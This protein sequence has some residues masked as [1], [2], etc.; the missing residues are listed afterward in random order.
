MA[1]QKS[2][3]DWLKTSQQYWKGWQDLTRQA[4]QGVQAEQTAA[5]WHEGLE[6]WSR[7][8]RGGPG[9]SDMNNVLDQLL[10]HGRGYLNFLQQIASNPGSFGADDLRSAAQR[11]VEELR[12]ASP[13]ASAMP[14]AGS[15]LG[16]Q[17]T[18]AL[19]WWQESVEP[20]REQA[21]GWSRMPAFGMAREYTEQAQAL[22]AA[23]ERLKDANQR[24]GALIAKALEGGLERFQDKLAARFEPG[25][26][27]VDDMRA[28]YDLFIDGLEEAY[29]ETA[30][31]AEFRVVYGDLVNA[32]SD[33]RLKIQRVVEQFS[34]TL[35][36]P[37]RSEINT[38][39]ARVHELRRAAKRGDDHPA[40][41]SLKGEIDQLRREL[42][43]LKASQHGA[44]HDDDDL[45]VAPRRAASGRKPAVSTRPVAP[46]KPAKST[47]P[48]T[49]RAV[50]AAAK[51][52]SK[53]KPARTAKPAARSTTRTAKGK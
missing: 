1:A 53:A 32:Q 15:P 21:Q 25:A 17:F 36:I 3:E 41:S 51:P 45:P 5:P 8:F 46:S 48:A 43:A 31:S 19:K 50:K 44:G 9:Q 22:S 23:Q 42:A 12:I 47:S 20:M 24:Y 18:N 10:D 35:G 37:T 27:R 52:A 34:G 6:Q 16:E 7:M 2:G 29:A 11:M 4:M 14:F 39:E 28:L 40:I 30:L 49:S 13:F 26:R 38:L 33:L